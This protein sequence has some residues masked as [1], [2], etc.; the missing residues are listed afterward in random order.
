MNGALS[1]DYCDLYDR[2]VKIVHSPVAGLHCV[3]V[4]CVIKC[5]KQQIFPFS[6]LPRFP[7]NIT[8]LCHCP[9]FSAVFCTAWDLDHHCFCD[10][11][12]A[13]VHKILRPDKNNK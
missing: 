4:C 8:L 13:H 11:A 6:F 10:N 3:N 12:L 2:V 9:L 7:L 5:W 1:W